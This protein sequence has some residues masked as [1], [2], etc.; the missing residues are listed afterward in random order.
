MIKVQNGKVYQQHEMMNMAHC[1]MIDYFE[2]YVRNK[3]KKKVS[4]DSKIHYPRRVLTEATN[5]FD[6]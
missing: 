6:Y 3:N 5:N 2:S 4:P 1:N